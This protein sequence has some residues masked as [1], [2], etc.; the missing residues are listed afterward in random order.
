MESDWKHSHALTNIPPCA[1][2]VPTPCCS[3][4]WACRTLG[5]LLGPSVS[6]FS[7][8][9]R[10]YSS[11]CI[12][13]ADSLPRV[14]DNKPAAVSR[15]ASL[16]VGRFCHLQKEEGKGK[17][18]G[19]AKGRMGLPL[20]SGKSCIRDL[21]LNPWPTILSLLVDWLRGWKL[22]SALQQAKVR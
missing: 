21:E 15:G 7:S 6:V 4:N 12:V 20:C 11:Y 2:S 9:F 18:R 19:R 10:A 13:L 14:P 1:D 8:S 5:V 3:G 17:R 16:C 22:L